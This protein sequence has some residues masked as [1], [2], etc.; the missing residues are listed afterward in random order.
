MSARVDEVVGEGVLANCKGMKLKLND[1]VDLI[2]VLVW[3][4]VVTRRSHLKD[5]LRVL[6]RQ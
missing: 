1:L 5:I 3:A 4:F 6:F 2:V